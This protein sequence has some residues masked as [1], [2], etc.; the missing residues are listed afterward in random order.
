MLLVYEM[1]VCVCVCVVIRYNHAC[2]C[3]HVCAITRE[4]CVY[5]CVIRVRAYVPYMSVMCMVVYVTSIKGKTT[6]SRF[7]LVAYQQKY[8]TLT[9][10]L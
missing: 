2:R 1:C 7:E 6:Y 3:N 10:A 9:I 4:I 5:V 8:F